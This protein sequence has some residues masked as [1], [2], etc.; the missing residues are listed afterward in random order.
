MT[1]SSPSNGFVKFVQF[2]ARFYFSRQLEQDAEI[3]PYGSFT[4]AAIR[5]PEYFVAN[6][7]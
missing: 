5:R 4:G 6:P 7:S 2:V 1:M 3:S